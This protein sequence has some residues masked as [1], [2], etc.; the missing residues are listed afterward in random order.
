LEELVRVRT[1][2]DLWRDNEKAD[3][4]YEHVLKEL[5]DDVRLMMDIVERL[6]RQGNREG[7]VKP[8]STGTINLPSEDSDEPL[9][10]T[11]YSPESVKPWER[12]QNERSL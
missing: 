4:L 3:E 5:T 11:D 10:L 7:K 1:K 6:A 2:R 8:A 12:P 9:I